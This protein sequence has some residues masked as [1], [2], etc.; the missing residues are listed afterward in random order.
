LRISL[1]HLNSFQ[2]DFDFAYF[3][4]ELILKMVE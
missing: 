4:L 3:K 1:G 2:I